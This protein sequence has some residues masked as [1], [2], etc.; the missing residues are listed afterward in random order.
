MLESVLGVELD[1]NDKMIA[2]EVRIECLHLV[3]ERNK[4]LSNLVGMYGVLCE[5]YFWVGEKSYA[6]TTKESLCGQYSF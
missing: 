1:N 5:W 4:A 2:S 6:D 3:T